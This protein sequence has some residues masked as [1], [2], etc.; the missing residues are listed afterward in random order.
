MG[1]GVAPMGVLHQ[2]S[3]S[4]IQTCR[5]SHMCL[6]LHVYIISWICRIEYYIRVLPMTIACIIGLTLLAKKHKATAKSLPW[7][8]HWLTSRQSGPWFI[9]KGVFGGELMS[10]SNFSTAQWMDSIESAGHLAYCSFWVEK[11]TS[12]TTPTVFPTRIKCKPLVKTLVSLGSIQ[13]QWGLNQRVGQAA[14]EYAPVDS[15][16]F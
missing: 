13:W 6:H 7:C 2:E 11:R 3:K 8:F 9:E 14:W 5:K 1:V 16:G 10:F 4:L 12:S 15:Y